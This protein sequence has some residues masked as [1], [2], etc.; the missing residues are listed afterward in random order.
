M[1]PKGNFP[2]Q[3]YLNGDILAPDQ[4]KISVFDRGFFFG[5]GIYEVMVQLENG[6]FYKKAHLDRLQRNL[7]EIGIGYD[8]DQLE[9]AVEP[10]LR[11]SGLTQR[12]CLIY[13]QISRGAAPRRHAFPPDTA[14]TVMMYA[15]P[16]ALPRIN[17]KSMEGVTLEDLRWH[18]CHIKS[19]SL[20]ANVMANTAAVVDGFDEGILVRDGTI[21]E[22]S[23]TNIFFVKDGSLLTHPA[24]RHILNG[25]DRKRT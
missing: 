8:V 11:A 10:L 22:G 12:E 13:M 14:P 7:D 17:E 24:D 6:I 21:T 16:T 5:D 23:H 18:M 19:P 4:A 15:L 9:K 1:L 3:V 2:A 20:L 25:L